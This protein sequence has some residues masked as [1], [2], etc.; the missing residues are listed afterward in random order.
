MSKIAVI[1][2]AAGSSTRFGKE[3]KKQFTSVAGRAAFLRSIELFD[4]RDD[5][6][7]IILAISQDDQ[8]IINIRYGA[9]L[10]FFGVKLCIGGSERFQTVANALAMV[11]DDIDLIAVHDAVRCCATKEWIDDVFETAAKTKA[12]MLAAPVVATIK[13]AKDNIITETVDRS[14]LYEAQT[15]QV[16]DAKLLKNAYAKLDT[17]DKSKITDDAQLVEAMGQKVSIVPTDSSNIKITTPCDVAIAEAIIKTRPKPEKTDDKSHGPFN[18][19]I[20]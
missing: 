3:K 7:Q 11:K 5:V 17:F 8:E 6:K 12:A 14:D 20:W 18:E 2:C 16:F 10:S 1:I 15:P 4:D 19:N 9:N 13:R